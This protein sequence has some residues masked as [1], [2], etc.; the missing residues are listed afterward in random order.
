MLLLSNGKE[1]YLIINQNKIIFSL[2]G[3]GEKRMTNKEYGIIKQTIEGTD[4]WIKNQIAGTPL[5]PSIDLLR[6]PHKGEDLIVAYRPFKVH[7]P[8][9][10]N[11]QPMQ[12]E[13]SHSEELR[14]ISFREPTTSESISAFAVFGRPVNVLGLGRIVKTP[15]G[16]FVNPLRDDKNNIITD[17]STLKHFLSKCQEVNGIWLYE[18]SDERLRDFGFVPYKQVKE[19]DH[20][21]FETFVKGSLARALEHTKE[22]EA[23][24]LKR[25]CNENHYGCKDGVRIC[26]LGLD[27][28]EHQAKPI[29]E[30]IKLSY[31]HFF[32]GNEVGVR[33]GTRD[34]CSRDFGYA[35]GVLKGEWKKKLNIY[36]KK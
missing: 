30:S 19:G 11:L 3:K 22:K 29:L 10:G 36:Q 26:N 35:F 13:Y 28:M 1:N 9:Q 15:E 2:R 21:D 34:D 4:L 7:K 33:D 14:R 18:G 24:N 12:R 8:Y 20:Q 16:I 31:I 23:K 6:V 27:F 5:P 32:F 25:I 17:E